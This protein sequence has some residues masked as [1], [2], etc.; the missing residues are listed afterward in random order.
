L[1]D[2]H[3]MAYTQAQLE[4]MLIEVQAAIT[5]CLT[6]QEYQ[7]GAGLSLRRASL[8]ELQDREKWILS[9]LSMY[10]TPGTSSP[11]INKVQFERPL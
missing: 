1:T 2:T 11:C 6:A 9:E 10:G 5:K 4:A 3:S 8:K 7:A